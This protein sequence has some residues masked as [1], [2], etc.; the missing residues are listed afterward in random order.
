MHLAT[1]PVCRARFDLH[2]S[3]A[4]PFCSARCRRIDLGR[5]FNEDYA[6]PA[7]SEEDEPEED[8]PDE[9]ESEE[10]ERQQS[11]SSDADE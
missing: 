2:G 3:S 7:N 4:P 8:E 11:E 5:W 10:D 1:C 6:L 9:V